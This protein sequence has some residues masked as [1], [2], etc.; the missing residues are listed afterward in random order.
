MFRVV[1]PDCGLMQAQQY[2]SVLA[3]LNNV[4]SKTLFNPVFMSI[5]RTYISLFLSP[6]L[7]G[8]SWPS[9]IHLIE[10][11]SNPAPTTFTVL[12]EV[13]VLGSSEGWTEVMLV[14]VE[15]SPPHTPHESLI[16]PLLGTPSHP[17]HELLSPP[18]IPRREKIVFSHSL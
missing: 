6:N 8:L 12:P 9:K 16:W 18:Q 17:M 2:R 13:E 7:P 4:G 3:T 1:T 14:H 15:P 10:S 11:P 5:A